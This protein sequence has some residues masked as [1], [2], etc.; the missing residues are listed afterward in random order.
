MSFTK[1]VIHK[2][3]SYDRLK[4]E[5]A[6]DLTPDTEDVVID[7]R[8]IGINYADC[9]I[10]MG[11]YASAKEYVGWPITPGFEVAGV[12]RSLGAGVA[13]LHVGQRVFAVTLFNGYAE[14]VCVPR[15]QVFP[16]S[17]QLAFE[18]AAAVPAVFAT[19]Y[20]GLLELCHPRKGQHVLIHSAAGG[21]GGALVQLAKIS[22]CTVTGVVGAT[23][24]CEAA[25]DFGAD[26][27]IDKSSDDLWET[28]EGYARE[29]FDIIADANGV[30]TLKQSYLHLRRPGKLLVYGFHTM[31]P[32]RGGKP[33]WP[34]LASGFFRTPRFNPLDMTNRSASVLA[35]NLS[36]LFD[37]TWLLAE[38]MDK[39]LDWLKKGLIQPPPLK[40]YPLEQVAEAHQALESGTTVGKL[41]LVP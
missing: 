34:K 19:A 23:H 7:V 30:A 33:N 5:T 38:T 15:H 28:A 21:V 41:I 35:F 3:G 18:E 40:T 6:S 9:I 20:Y 2:A 32:K 8:A 14:Q 31:M 29:G 26:Y 1:V 17:A 25:R 10:R 22:G 12:V 24:K 13:D 37:E 4:L 36:Y 11:L 39:I 16:M 27:V